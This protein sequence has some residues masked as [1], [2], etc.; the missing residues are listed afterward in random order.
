MLIYFGAKYIFGVNVVKMGQ[1][2][3]LTGVNGHGHFSNK[4]SKTAIIP[5]LYSTISIVDSVV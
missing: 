2:F 3:G 4:K 5:S 1:G